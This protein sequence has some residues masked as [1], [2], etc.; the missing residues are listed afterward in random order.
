[1]NLRNSGVVDKLIICTKYIFSYELAKGTDI[2]KE[3]IK[4]K[5]ALILKEKELKF[6]TEKEYLEYKKS[7]C[8]YLF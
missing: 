1:M 5:K 3:V 2:K 7:L 4:A 8:S 6:K